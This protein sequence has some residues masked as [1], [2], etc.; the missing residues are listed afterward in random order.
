MEAWYVLHSMA[1]QMEYMI[2][3]TGSL[4]DLTQLFMEMD[5]YKK[6]YDDYMAKVTKEERPPTPPKEQKKKE[7]ER[8]KKE[9]LAKDMRE[10]EEK[11]NKV[12][13]L[14]RQKMIVNEKNAEEVKAEEEKEEEELWE[15]EFE[16]KQTPG[17]VVSS[18]KAGFAVIEDFKVCV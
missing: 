17:V 6:K 1:A 4:Q 15:E 3:L 10:K 5:Q 14:E 13:L 18:K 16:K 12:S 7:K 2:A 8:K 11:T 9:K